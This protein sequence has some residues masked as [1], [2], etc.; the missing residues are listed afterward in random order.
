MILAEGLLDEFL[1][2]HG[3]QQRD[4]QSQSWQVAGRSIV[5]QKMRQEHRAPEDAGPAGVAAPGSCAYHVA[6]VLLLLPHCTP[7]SSFLSP[8]FPPPVG[9]LPTG[10]HPRSL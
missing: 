1:G 6:P 7:L 9:V 10:G 4:W 2:A 8:F 3:W 5:P